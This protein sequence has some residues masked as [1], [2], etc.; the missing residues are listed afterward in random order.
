MK[1]ADTSEKGLESLIVK[2]LTA[3]GWITGDSRD[4]EREYCV[5]LVQLTA[6]LQATQPGLVSV[7]IGGPRIVSTLCL[8]QSA[9]KKATPL[10]RRTAQLLRSLSIQVCTQ[11]VLE[12]EAARLARLR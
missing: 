3:C 10:V 1:V 12:D 4:Y 7:P 8:V 2:D 11:T 6:F 9:K 5:D